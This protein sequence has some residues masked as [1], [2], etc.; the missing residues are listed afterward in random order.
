M[1]D[2]GRFAYDNSQFYLVNSAFMLS[3]NNIKYL[4]A[5]LNSQIIDW[6]M[7]KIAST[8]GM[9]T[10]EWTKSS[11]EKIPIPQ[12]TT[13]KEIVSEIVDRVIE[14]KA[15]DPIVNT[16]DLETEVERTVC[17][18]YMLTEREIKTITNFVKARNKK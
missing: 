17:E 3:G 5:F 15:T 4:T 10:I 13:F 16:S 8:S 6:Y 12:I 9:G 18:Y 7:A 14:L 2:K 11:V 1:A